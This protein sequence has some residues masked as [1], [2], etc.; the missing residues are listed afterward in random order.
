MHRLAPRLTGTCVL[1]HETYTRPSCRVHSDRYASE[2]Y[3]G[4]YPLL[5]E[6]L[7]TNDPMNARRVMHA[8][9]ALTHDTASV[10]EGRL[11]V[12]PCLHDVHFINLTIFS[13]QRVAPANP[14]DVRIEYKI[15][16]NASR[17]PYFAEA[18]IEFINKAWMGG[19][20]LGVNIP[21]AAFP[22]AT[23]LIAGTENEDRKEIPVGGVAF[24]ATMVRHFL[25]RVCWQLSDNVT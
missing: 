3:P 4:I 20:K 8:I 7:E 12:R 2:M 17:N 15:N 1:D 10:F 19:D 23:F 25:W 18:I 21:H 9:S 5:K 11:I 13:L 14:E 22:N 16:S 6:L 24:A